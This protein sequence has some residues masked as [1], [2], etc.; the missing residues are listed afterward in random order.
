[1]KQITITINNE[2][3]GVKTKKT[4]VVDDFELENDILNY[5]DR[6]ENMKMT[7]KNHHTKKV[8]RIQYEDSSDAKDAKE[9][10]GK[11]LDGSKLNVKQLLY[12]EDGTLKIK[13]YTFEDN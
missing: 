5:V 3:N 2:K 12:P 8:Y 11:E 13:K 10:N 4:V 6:I 7:K 9:L 1:M